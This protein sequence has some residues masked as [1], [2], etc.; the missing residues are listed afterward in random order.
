MSRFYW[1]NNP[2]EVK[3]FS[4]GISLLIREKNHLDPFWSLMEESTA[5]DRNDVA[6]MRERRR[7]AAPWRQNLP[8][9]LQTLFQLRWEFPCQPMMPTAAAAPKP[10]NNSAAVRMSITIVADLIKLLLL[11]LF[12]S[13]NEMAA[14][15][16]A[17]AFTTTKYLKRNCLPQKFLIKRKILDCLYVGISLHTSDK[18]KISLSTFLFFRLSKILMDYEDFYISVCSSVLF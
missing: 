12:E 4:G 5:R 6:P 1:S 3:Y 16:H 14:Y 10:E 11:P 13:T 18:K 9:T 8:K 2:Y 15:E 7:E 17:I